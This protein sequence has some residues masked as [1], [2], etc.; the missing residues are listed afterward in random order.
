M[1]QMTSYSKN[2]GDK[3]K[4]RQDF[5]ILESRPL[6]NLP[7]AQV[8][9]KNIAQILSR[10]LTINDQDKF[11]SRIF[12]TVREMFTVIKAQL[13]DVPTSQEIHAAHIDLSADEPRFDQMRTSIEN[14]R[15]H[16]EHKAANR[17]RSQRQNREAAL[18]RFKRSGFEA[19]DYKVGSRHRDQTKGRLLPK[20]LYH[21][22]PIID[23]KSFKQEFLK[24]QKDAVLYQ[25][26]NLPKETAY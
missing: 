24:G 14:N 26:P 6:I 8:L 23:P 17:T 21:G 11:S 20:S 10:W 25:D 3:P 18:K 4:D 9:K 2:F 13:H 7:C 12:Y 16:S 22:P 1:T 15:R 19:L 5:S